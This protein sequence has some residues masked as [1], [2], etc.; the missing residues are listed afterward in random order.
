MKPLSKILAEIR[1]IPDQVERSERFCDLA[2]DAEQFAAEGDLDQAREIFFELS[3]LD[4]YDDLLHPAIEAAEIFLVKSGDIPPLDAAV[5]EAR[6]IAMYAQ[7]DG[8]D[9]LMAVSMGLATAKHATP[10]MKLRALSLA[11]EAAAISPLIKRH[12]VFVGQLRAAL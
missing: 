12:F 3:K 9:K 2:F 4:A 7:L 10:E 6:L 5:E 8:Y 1:S 11:D